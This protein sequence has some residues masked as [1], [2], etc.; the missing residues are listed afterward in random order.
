MTACANSFG[1]LIALS[2]A[3]ARAAVLAL[4]QVTGNRLG[5]VP[6]HFAR[7]TAARVPQAPH[8]VDRCTDA[9]AKLGCY[10][11]A[12]HP[13]LLNRRNACS[14]PG[15]ARNVLQRYIG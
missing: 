14:P 4:K 3:S 10:R 9:D 15:A 7:R 6:A 8:P 2:L 5:L 11:P 1:G 13:L 12:G